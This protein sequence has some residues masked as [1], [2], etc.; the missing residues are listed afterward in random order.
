M[1]TLQQDFEVLYLRG[2]DQLIENLKAI[3]E[4]QLWA[5]PEGVANSCGVLA[6]HLIGNLNHYIGHGIGDTGYIR[7]RDQEFRTTDIT[8]EELI[9]ETKK[10]KKTLGKI[11]QTMDRDEFIEDF[12]LELPVE[13]TKRGVLVHLYGHL[14]YHLGQFNYLRRIQSE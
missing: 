12:S 8:K 4:E 7:H 2:L 9:Q 1:N 11:F 6:Q 14:N 10:L 13:M 3:P 5:A